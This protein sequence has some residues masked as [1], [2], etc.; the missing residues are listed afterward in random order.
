[1]FEVLL[2]KLNVFFNLSIIFVVHPLKVS[3]HVLELSLLFAENTNYLGLMS[4]ALKYLYLLNPPPA[5]SLLLLS[6]SLS[7]LL[8]ELH[9]NIL[10]KGWG[11]PP[12]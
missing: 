7:C 6:G 8:S 10:L 1:M 9:S 5:L 3:C 4:W 2:N 12:V 11:I